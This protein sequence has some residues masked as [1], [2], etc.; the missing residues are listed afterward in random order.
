MSNLSPNIKI[1]LA[2]KVT[3]LNWFMGYK[4]HLDKYL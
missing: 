2:V 1:P 3:T 4:F